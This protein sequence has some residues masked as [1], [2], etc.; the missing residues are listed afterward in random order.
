MLKALVAI[1]TLLAAT[2]AP[3]TPAAAPPPPAYTVG[4]NGINGS[5]CPAG[6]GTVQTSS[7]GT[8]FTIRF[9]S[10]FTAMVGGSAK[11]AN[12]R[13]NCQMALDV[14]GPRGYTYALVG[15]DYR[16][17]ASLAPGAS[18]LDGLSYYFT[19]ASHT[20]RSERT[21]P[22]PFRGAW[23]HRDKAGPLH[24]G[25]CGG[26]RNLNINM[27]VR[28]NAGRPNAKAVSWMSVSSLNG[29]RLAWKRC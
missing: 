12:A 2:A 11:P 10:H 28:V 5:G 17:R 22:G 7:D 21:I 6:T 23:Q 15:I 4:L 24:Y 3:A 1:A 8:S 18:G 29:F 19:G 9:S 25:P 20:S 14:R 27:E 13:R 16:G 26:L